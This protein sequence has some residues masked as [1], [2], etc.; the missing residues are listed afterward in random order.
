MDY[1]DSVIGVLRFHD[2]LYLDLDVAVGTIEIEGQAYHKVR[3]ATFVF[4][5]VEKFHVSIASIWV[6]G[7]EINEEVEKKISDSQSG[8][9]IEPPEGSISFYKPDKEQMANDFN[10]YITT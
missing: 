8:W 5:D 10:F 3:L 6:N 9:E 4:Y 2:N 1:H 7:I